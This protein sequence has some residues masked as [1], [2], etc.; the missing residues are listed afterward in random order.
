[1]PRPKTGA[2]EAQVESA[3]SAL[4]A[5]KAAT[6]DGA[7]QSTARIR[8]CSDYTRIIAPFDGVV[9]WRYAD[10]GALVQ[11]GTSSS[12]G[13][14]VVKLAQVDVLRL[15]IPVPESLAAEVGCA[16]VSRPTLTVQATGEHFTGKVTPLYR[17]ARPHHPHHAGG[18][19][20]AQRHL[21]TSA[22]HV[23]RGQPCECR[24]TTRCADRAGAGGAATQWTK[25]A[26]WWSIQHNRVQLREIQ[27]GLE[28]PIAGRSAGRVC[29]QATA[30][31]SAISVPIRPASVVEPKVEQLRLHSR[32]SRRRNANK[33]P[34]SRFGIPS[35]SS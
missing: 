12:N 28:D 30:S 17:C 32:R 1:M 4:A 23:R 9:T 25:P 29:R 3:K 33:C 8:A 14:P 24:T 16:S 27:T 5:A 11:A 21:Q 7:S 35:S 15:R 31:S 13:L 26:C 19:R 22:G 10:T 18:D 20:R 2:S 34:A 6:G